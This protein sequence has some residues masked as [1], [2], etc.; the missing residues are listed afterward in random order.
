[1]NLIK[2]TAIGSMA[3]LAAVIIYKEV[4]KKQMN[5]I[6]KKGKH[7]AKRIGII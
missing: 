4:D 3:T 1:M 6:M 2:G 7:I 5:K